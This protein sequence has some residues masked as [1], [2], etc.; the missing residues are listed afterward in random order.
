MANNKLETII[1]FVVL[2]IA[3]GFI[4]FTYKATN[5]RMLEN[6]YSLRAKFDNVEGIV[7]GSD[8]MLSGIKVGS[9]ETLKLDADTYKAVMTIAI[10]KGVKLP[11][12]SSVKVVSAGL[13]GGKY[14]L[15]D[16]G[17]DEEMLVSGND[18]RY[19]QSSINLESLVSKMM[20][21]FQS[22]K[23]K[24]DSMIKQ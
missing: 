1:G 21:N 18:I 12:D 16:V 5:L 19:T 6:T 20:F 13:L 10:D 9:V 7:V 8:V 2:I 24:A 15:V 3:I 4:V 22:D 11:T 17:A 23:S 14:V